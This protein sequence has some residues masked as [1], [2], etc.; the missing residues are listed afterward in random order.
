MLWQDAA[1]GQLVASKSLVVEAAAAARFAGVL[2]GGATARDQGQRSLRDFMRRSRARV[3]SRRPW[4]RYFRDVGG[5]VE[6]ESGSEHQ[7]TRAYQV[8]LSDPGGLRSCPTVVPKSFLVASFERNS[9]KCGRLA[10]LWAAT[11][12][13]FGNVW[14]TRQTLAKLGRCGQHR[15]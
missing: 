4:C 14:P 7:L 15:R 13:S 3:R 8:T 1:S 9:G 12:T 5:L 6:A 10:W 11:L 2:A